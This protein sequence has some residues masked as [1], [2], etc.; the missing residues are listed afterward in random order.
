MEP[1]TQRAF[2]YQVP[3]P[4][5]CILSWRNYGLI[6]LLRIWYVVNLFIRMYSYRVTS[7]PLLFMFF[8][9]GC[10]SEFTKWWHTS[11]WGELCSRERGLHCAGPCY[12]LYYEG[13]STELSSSSSDQQ[14]RKECNGL[15][16]GNNDLRSVEREI[17]NCVQRK[18]HLI[19]YNF[20][21]WQHCVNVLSCA[22][23]VR[24]LLG[25]AAPYIHSVI[26]CRAMSIDSTLY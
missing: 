20:T 16:G 18:P 9:Q 23:A 24:F 15:F 25:G 11:R 22:P 19:E 26:L 6:Y 2:V 17:N 10:S 4:S 7:F 12:V 3:I 14:P 8:S 13:H 5:K 21:R 1:A